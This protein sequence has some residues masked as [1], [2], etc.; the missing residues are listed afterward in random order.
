MANTVKKLLLQSSYLC[1]ALLTFHCKHLL[2]CNFRSVELLLPAC[3]K[4]LNSSHLLGHISNSSRRRSRGFKITRRISLNTNCTKNLVDIPNDQQ[5]WITSPA[6]H[7]SSSPTWTML[8][9]S[10]GNRCWNTMEKLHAPCTLMQFLTDH[11]SL[12]N[13]QT[14]L[15]LRTSLQAARSWF[16]CRWNWLSIYPL[17]TGIMQLKKGDVALCTVT[18]L[19]IGIV[20][21]SLCDNGI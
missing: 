15:T 19:L 18:L 21:T 17:N 14:L 4:L 5:V 12:N 9:I 7:L 8:H 6:T 20:Y 10:S 13:L 11:L 16:D 2:S 1:L 3:L